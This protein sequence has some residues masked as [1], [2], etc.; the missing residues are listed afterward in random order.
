MSHL[1]DVFKT[2]IFKV[3]LLIYFKDLSMFVKKI[4]HSFEVVLIL[5]MDNQLP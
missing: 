3:L 2:V 4:I 1:S 5:Q